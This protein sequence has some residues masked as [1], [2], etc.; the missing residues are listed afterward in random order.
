MEFARHDRDLL[1]VARGEERLAD[2]ATA[3]EAD[4][5][6]E[7]AAVP[8]D[9]GAEGAVE[10]LWE[11][12]TADGN[13]PGTLVNNVGI[14]VHGV[15][16]DSDRE[17]QAAQLRLNVEVLVSL[18]HRFLAARDQGAVLNI[19]SIAGL[20]PGARM[21]GYYASKAY[22]NSFSQALAA[23]HRGTDITVTLV[24]PG[25]VRT[26]FH[27]RA[28]IDPSAVGEYVTYEPA[29]IASA[30]YAGLAAGEALVIP[31]YLMKGLSLLNR[32]APAAVRRRIGAWINRER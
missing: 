25:P 3:L 10:T 22:V 12:V 30:A 4:H 29:E 7:A 32:L 15:F 31:G 19:G 6:V 9:L 17:R 2:L 23:E 24:C 26:E 14:G 28:G 18:T 8:M 21:A 11:R 27:E 13:P 5:G 20:L 1:L 16:A